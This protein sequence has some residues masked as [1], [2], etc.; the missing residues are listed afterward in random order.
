MIAVSFILGYYVAAQ[1]AL[2]VSHTDDQIIV[3]WQGNSTTLYDAMTTQMPNWVNGQITTA[4]AQLTAQLI[5]Q[6]PAGQVLAGYGNG[7][8]RIC[9][10]ASGGGLTYHPI[11]SVSPYFVPAPILFNYTDTSNP[12]YPANWTTINMNGPTFLNLSSTALAN[13]KMLKLRVICGESYI[14]MTGEASPPASVTP[15]DFRRV[16]GASNNQGD[17]ADVDVPVTASG[18]QLPLKFKAQ[19]TN[20]S[21]VGV[22]A[23]LLGYYT[24]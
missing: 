11:E 19:A 6:C 3:N 2:T 10:S 14:W 21:T 8:T 1:S 12:G 18:V 20:P 9:V 13:V 7:L 22:T 4:V 5:G 16:C 24:N 15:V 17:N 23:F